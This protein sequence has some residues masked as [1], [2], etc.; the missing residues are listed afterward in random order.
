[1]PWHI[2]GR[3][4]G[5]TSGPK[6]LGRGVAG[7]IECGV[8][9]GGEGVSMGLGKDAGMK[10][11]HLPTALTWLIILMSVTVTTIT[12]LSIS[13]ISTNGKVK[14]GSTSPGHPRGGLHPGAALWT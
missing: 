13:A 4:D 3:Q 2:V 11:C 10:R 5:N 6:H 1:M 8:M 14:S 12:G 7:S 9:R